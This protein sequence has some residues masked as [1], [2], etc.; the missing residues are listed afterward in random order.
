MHDTGKAT[1]SIRGTRHD[2]VPIG[3]VFASGSQKLSVN[4]QRADGK[5]RQYV[6]SLL[7][8]FYLNCPSPYE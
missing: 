7:A 2:I 8:A 4:S 3:K 6:L 5:R 1:E